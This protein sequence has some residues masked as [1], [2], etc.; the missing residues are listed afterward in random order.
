MSMSNPG[1]TQLEFWHNTLRC[2]EFQWNSLFKSEH[3]QSQNPNKK[4]HQWNVVNQYHVWMLTLHYSFYFRVLLYHL[5]TR[6]QS[7]NVTWPGLLHLLD[8]TSVDWSVNGKCHDE[9][10]SKS[11]VADWCFRVKLRESS[12]AVMYTYMRCTCWTKLALSA[13]RILFS[14]SGYLRLRLHS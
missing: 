12:K 2:M 10:R 3:Q 6:L 1:I 7:I 5:Q 14:P 8:C 13:M 4:W 11:S 9:S